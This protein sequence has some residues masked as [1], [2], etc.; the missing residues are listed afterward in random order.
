M[1]TTGFVVCERKTEMEKK[2]AI[3]KSLTVINGV[4]L[5]S[6]SVV[7]FRPARFLLES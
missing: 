5:D 7:A 1:R 2:T 3:G 6:G 4:C